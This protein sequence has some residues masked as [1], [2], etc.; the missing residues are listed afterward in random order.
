MS[1]KSTRV[2]IF[3]G[4]LLVIVIAS[5]IIVQ[6][7]LRYSAHTL[8]LNIQSTYN[9]VE[10]K[11]WDN[12]V[13]QLNIFERKW[14]KTKYVWAIF[15]DHF[16]IDNIENSYTKSMEYITNKDRS[17]SA[18]ELKALKQYVLHIP[19]KESFSLENIL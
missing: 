3:V 12:A 11:D 14:N 5:G 13:K 2:L 6:Y 16:E 18:A 19:K 1:K 10:N 9:A 4:I 17:L 15:L 8:D 7:Y